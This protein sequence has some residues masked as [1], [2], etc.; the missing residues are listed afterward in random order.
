MQSA[1]ITSVTLKQLSSEVT[2]MTEK[3]I[4]LLEKLSSIQ[5]ELKAP[6]NQYNKFGKYNYRNCE[7]ILEAVKPLCKKNKTTLIISDEA[8]IYDGWHY[9]KAVA[10][11]YDW[12]SDQTI[13]CCAYA[14][15]S[16]AKKGMDES[17]ITG[18]TS[19]YARK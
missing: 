6:K 1:V 12:E 7:D 2:S 5:C 9:I 8:E 16:V 15:E 17:Q 13:K 19:S 3:T 4:S 11:L 18:S 14:R 10:E